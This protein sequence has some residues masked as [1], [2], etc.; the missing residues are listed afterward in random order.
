MLIIGERINSTIKSVRKAIMERDAEFLQNLAKSQVEGGADYIDVNVSTEKGGSF[1]IENMEWTVEKVQEI[2]D[3]PL[4]IDS[5]NPETLEAGLRKCQQKAMINSISAEPDKLATI[6][7]LA[8]EFDAEIIALAIGEEGIPPD[9]EGRFR[10]CQKI[11]ESAQKHGIA[12]GKLYF[13]PLA[14]AVSADTSQGIITL[15]TLRRIKSQLPEAKTILGLSNISF[16]LPGRSLVN[17]SFL[18]M[19]MYAGLDSAIMD[20]RDR[21]LMSVIKAGE[22]VLGKDN[23]C[24]NYLK[25]Y[26]KGLLEP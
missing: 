16:G 18:L 13:D 3:K 24:L 14:L 4:T 12:L 17:G 1:D 22:M 11:A 10:A 8:R 6:L 2:V 25:A 7:P 21:K 15:E 9:V 19:A 5:P 23:Y 20:P 26:R